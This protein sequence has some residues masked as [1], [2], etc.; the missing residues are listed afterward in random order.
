M[1]DMDRRKSKEERY[2]KKEKM[3]TKKEQRK[4]SK[5]DTEKKGRPKRNGHEMEEKQRKIN[6]ER[7]KI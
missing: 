7:R 3:D 2:D 5:I 1:M 4:K 6:I